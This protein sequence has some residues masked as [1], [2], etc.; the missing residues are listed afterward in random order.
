M[1]DF[2]L[3]IDSDFTFAGTENTEEKNLRAL[4]VSVRDF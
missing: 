3:E 4:C 1:K 2:I